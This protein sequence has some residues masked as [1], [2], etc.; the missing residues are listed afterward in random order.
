MLAPGLALAAR[1]AVVCTLQTALP[2]QTVVLRTRAIVRSAVAQ[3][4]KDRRRP[5]LPCIVCFETY[6]VLSSSFLLLRQPSL[7]FTPE[8]SRSAKQH[9]AGLGHYKA[10]AQQSQHC[11]G[12]LLQTPEHW[13]IKT[14][15]RSVLHLRIRR[16]PRCATTS[17]RT[18]TTVPPT[19]LSTHTCASRTPPRI[20][21]GSSSASTIVLSASKRTRPARTALLLRNRTRNQ[22]VPVLDLPLGGL[23]IRVPHRL[24]VPRV[25]NVR[26][27][28]RHA[29]PWQLCRRTSRPRG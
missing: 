16:R 26:T 6:H 29:E 3:N 10:L 21:R 27:W 8:P 18:T 25:D 9:W 28:R 7:A 13:F 12:S 22:R 20:P 24:L 5:P 1:L 19:Y 4:I 17:T 14:L 23:L 11:P 2:R 15:G